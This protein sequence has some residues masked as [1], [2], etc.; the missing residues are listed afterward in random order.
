[1]KV[2]ILYN[3]RPDDVSGEG[4]DTFEEYDEPET[5]A[6]IAQALRGMGVEPTPVAADPDTPWTLKHGGF[7]F[8]FNI[9]EGAGRA[10]ARRCRQPC[11]SFS[12]C[13]A[14]DP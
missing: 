6:A 4:D 5:I 14:P 13:P 3:P 10:A 12:G 7:D 11:A 8:V 2:A 9:A 1:M